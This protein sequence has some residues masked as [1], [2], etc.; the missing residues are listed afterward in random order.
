MESIYLKNKELE[1]L[2]AAKGIE[3]WFGLA[4]DDE[5]LH[6]DISTKEELF[7]LLGSLYQKYFIE[8]DEKKVR[9]REPVASVLKVVQN[10]QCCIAI[11]KQSDRRCC[12]CYNHKVILFEKPRTDV[13]AY[14]ISLIDNKEFL[15]SLW[16]EEWFPAEDSFFAS[17]DI[18]FDAKMEIVS[19]FKLINCNTGKI[20]ETMKLYTQGINA[21]IHLETGNQETLYDYERDRCLIILNR[22]IDWREK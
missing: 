9:I 6:A 2:L 18:A 5:N 17:K 3:W 19:E 22:W 13:G 20:L 16:E 15:D 11:S 14:R 8:W 12:Y 7:S 21:L 10:S 4:S 1:I